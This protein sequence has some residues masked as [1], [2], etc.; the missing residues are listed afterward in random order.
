MPSIPVSN[1]LHFLRE[2]LARPLKVASPVPSGRALARKI[3]EQIDPDPNGLVLELGPGTGA[4]TRAIREQ[5]VPDSD[6]VAVESEPR[7]VA[8]LRSQLPSVRIIEGD[9]FRF[10]ELLGDRA[11]DLRSIVSGL[12]V[13]GQPLAL[14]ERLLGDAMA[15]LRPRAPFIQ[16]SYGIMPPLPVRTGI[17]VQRAATVW[18]NIPPMQ[19]WVYRSAR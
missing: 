7:F 2:F 12:P 8:L 19:I 14:R 10:T 17:E 3:A 13:L 11:K 15:S 6:L 1:E 4:V 18:Q 5:G 9:A 16:F